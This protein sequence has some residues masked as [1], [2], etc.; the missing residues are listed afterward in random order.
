MKKQVL[1]FSA[2]LAFMTGIASAQSLPTALSQA[3]LDEMNARYSALLARV[4]AM[5]DL[6][7]P[8]LKVLASDI[9]KEIP[10]WER[11]LAAIA[12]ADTQSVANEIRHA[13]KEIDAKH[14]KIAEEIHLALKNNTPFSEYTLNQRNAMGWAVQDNINDLKNA[15]ESVQKAIPPNAR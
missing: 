2:I 3:E 7:I 14:D 4:K 5:G 11:L 10:Q 1:I 8:E 12:P 13:T 9:Q 6:K 15:A